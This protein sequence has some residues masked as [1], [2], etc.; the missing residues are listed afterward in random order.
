[1]RGHARG[2]GTRRDPHPNLPHLRGPVMSVAR[3]RSLWRFPGFVP[4]LCA[5]SL[6]SF[7]PQALA[8]SSA[9]AKSHWWD[10][11]AKTKHCPAVAVNVP[12]GLMGTNSKDLGKR[13]SIA[14]KTLTIDGTDNPDHI[15]LSPTEQ[16]GWVAVNW[17]GNQLGPYGPVTAV[18]LQGNGGDDALI[19]K[20]DLGIP[21]ILDGGDGDDCVQGGSGGDVIVGGNGD[22][23][24]VAGTGRPA[25]D[26]GSGNN[27]VVVAQHLG[28]IR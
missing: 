2:Y 15:V 23:L 12:P 26:S 10:S 20:P 6:V 3:V 24:V 16:P 22:D 1:M 9:S 21:V 11:A 5:V 25:L 17:N 28:K 19:A 7:V 18:V 27:K 13:I 8:E 14:K 4:V